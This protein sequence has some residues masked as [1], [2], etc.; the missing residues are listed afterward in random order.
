MA[1]AI[2]GLNLVLGYGGLFALGHSAFIGLGAF[3]TAWLVQDL[4]FDYW[5]VI[6]FSMAARS[7]LAR[8]LHYR[9]YALKVCTWW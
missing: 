3:V 9:R 5:M 2:M 4:R 6:P 8:Y 7:P 1:I